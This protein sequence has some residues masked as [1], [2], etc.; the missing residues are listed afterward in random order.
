[1]Y[2]HAIHTYLEESLLKLFLK[3]TCDGIK[4]SEFIE[5]D[6]LYLSVVNLITSQGI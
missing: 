3:G 5:S 4:L 1:M 2:K 6:E